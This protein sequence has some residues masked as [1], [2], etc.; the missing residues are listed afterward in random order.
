MSITVNL[1]QFTK[2]VSQCKK[3][4]DRVVRETYDYFVRATPIKTGNARRNTDLVQ[5]KIEANYPYAQRLDTGWSKQAPD[6]M[7]Q[8]TIDHLQNRIIPDAIRRI[9]RG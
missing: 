2:A 6:G 7:V 4:A 8:P 5:T 9:N 3:E 1:S